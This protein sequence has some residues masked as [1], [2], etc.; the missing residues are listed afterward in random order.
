MTASGKKV[1]TRLESACFNHPKCVCLKSKFKIKSMRPPARVKGFYAAVT[2]R[3]YI[4][5]RASFCARGS[6]VRNHFD[7]SNDWFRVK[8]GLFRAHLCGDFIEL[9]VFSTVRGKWF[10][11]GWMRSKGVWGVFILAFGNG[12]LSSRIWWMVLR[13]FEVF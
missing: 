6:S 3:L 12:K 11:E 8:V 1:P 10:W 7:V 4:L 2:L 5:A 13:I 9:A